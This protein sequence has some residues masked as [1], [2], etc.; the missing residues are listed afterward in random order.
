VTG[1]GPTSPGGEPADRINTSSDKPPAPD[2]LGDG[3][4]NLV[5]EPAPAST[6]LNLGRKAASGVVITALFAVLLEAVK[7]GGGLLTAHLLQPPD[8][9]VFGVAVVALY[10]ASAAL[11]FDLG[12][13]LVQ[14]QEDPG[15]LYD[16]AFT[17]QVWLGA[18]YVVFCL[19]AGP[20]L[21]RVY[22]DTRLVPV[23]IAMSLQ[24]VTLPSA[25]LLVYLQRELAWWRQRFIGSVGP[26]LGLMVTV[27]M[28]LAGFRLWALV[29]GQLASVLSTALMMW[30]SA[31]RR[32]RLVL[33]IPRQS[34]RFLLSF[35]WPL[36][37]VGIVTV[38]S[39]N[40]MVLEVQLVLGLAALGF[41]R[42]A[43][44]LGERIDTAENV[45]SSV[46]FPVI[47]RLDD[48]I[49]RQRAFDIS[50]RLILVWAVPTGLGL[51][52]FSHDIAAILGPQWE[53]IV[54]LLQIEGIAEVVNAIATMWGVFYMATGN[55]RPSLWAG[56]LVNMVLVVLILVLGR[57]FGLAG[58]GMAIGVAAVIALFQRR[59]FIRRLFPGTPV[60][61]TAVPMVTAG[62]VAAT[63]ALLVHR[64]EPGTG[65]RSVVVRLA[66]FLAVYVALAYLL[67]RRLIW[68][69]LALVRSDRGG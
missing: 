16:H 11:N 41:F 22:G 62:A 59:R 5:P 40:A 51:A 8:F 13:R 50:A 7:A 37:L 19:A 39:I 4:V 64:L 17:F 55:N 31:P 60:L 45:V 66:V 2:V 57:A 28:A 24:A 54:P 34:L 38:V 48:N 49:Q 68:Q 3:F 32:P 29:I 36:W 58:I 26:V 27:G 46:I 44:G 18:V 14:M 33:R 43:T 42:V 30:R 25:I 47:C 52:V 69:T 10:F 15:D 1:G 12:S 23:C 6:I 9:A 21:M 61:M 53:P 20:V 63:A 65:V 35:G 67:E 56:V